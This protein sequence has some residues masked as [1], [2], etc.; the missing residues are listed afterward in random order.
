[1]SDTP[2]RPLFPPRVDAPPAAPT[3]DMATAQRIERAV[4]DTFNRHFGTQ[5]LPF[6]QART[7]VLVERDVIGEVIRALAAKAPTP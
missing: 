2:P 7:L 6:T 4:M 1:V 3:L 5:M